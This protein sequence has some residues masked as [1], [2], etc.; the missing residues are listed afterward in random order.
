MEPS[1]E[2]LRH[3]LNTILDPLDVEVI[4][5]DLTRETMLY[6]ALEEEMFEEW[7]PLRIPMDIRPGISIHVYAKMNIK[8]LSI[9]T[10]EFEGRI[11]IDEKTGR[12]SIASFKL[13]DS[14][15]PPEEKWTDTIAHFL[16]RYGSTVIAVIVALLERFV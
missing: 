15:I 12:M 8:G 9:Y 4:E 7:K 11:V 10:I 16:E 14:R 5:L 2:V 6:P 13:I 1:E 3:T